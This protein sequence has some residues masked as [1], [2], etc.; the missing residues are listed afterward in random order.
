[1]YQ[2]KVAYGKKNFP[3]SLN[4]RKIN[5]KKGICP[6]AE[7]FNDISYVGINMCLYNYSDKEV[8]LLI[9]AFNKVWQSLD[10]LK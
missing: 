2:K 9:K 5:Y 3:W 8:N 10:S 7:N 4:R 1:M 6:V